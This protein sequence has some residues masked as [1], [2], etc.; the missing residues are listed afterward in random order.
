MTTLF[1][2]KSETNDD[3]NDNDNDNT[4]N[5]GDD[6]ISA[7]HFLKYSNHRRLDSVNIMKSLTWQLLDSIPSL[8]NPSVCIVSR[9]IPLRFNRYLQE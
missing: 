7:V 4:I 9:M 3:D 1:N 2:G 8:Q 5:N 6:T